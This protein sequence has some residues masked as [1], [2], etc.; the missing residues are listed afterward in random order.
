MKSSP[1]SEVWEMYEESADS[2]AEMMDQ[3]INLPVY[4]DELALRYTR[5]TPPALEP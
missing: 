1:S 4:S 2:Y 5:S 3:E